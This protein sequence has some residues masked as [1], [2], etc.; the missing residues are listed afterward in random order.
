MKENNMFMR[1]ISTFLMIA[2][3]FSTYFSLY[4]MSFGFEKQVKIRT[5]MGRH[6]NKIVDLRNVIDYSFDE[7]KNNVLKFEL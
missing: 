2:I 1:L 5:L 4:G 6:L 3:T 7:E